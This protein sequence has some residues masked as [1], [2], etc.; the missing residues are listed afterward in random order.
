MRGKLQKLT[1]KLCVI[2]LLMLTSLVLEQNTTSIK[3]APAADFTGAKSAVLKAYKSYQ[4]SVDLSK[5]HIYNTRD[6]DK[7]YEILSEVINRTPGIFY[8]GQ[9]YTKIVAPANDQIRAVRLTYIDSFVLESGAINV[10]KIKRVQSQIDTQVQKALKSVNKSMTKLE[11]AMVLHD[12]LVQNIEYYNSNSKAFCLSEWGAFIKGKANCQGYALAYG[13]LM[14]KIGVPVTYVS[15]E[16]MTHM[17]NQIKISGKWYHVDITW[18]DPLE[19]TT[20]KDQP[21]LVLHDTFLCS[22]ASMKQRGYSGFTCKTANSKKY[23]YKFW[24]TVNSEIYYRNHKW[25]YQTTTAI[26]ERKS[27]VSGGA[28]TLYKA[29]GNALV[30]KDS[31]HYY[32]I[33][34]DHIFMYNRKTGKMSQVYVK[35]TDATYK[36]YT[37]AQ[38]S[39]KTKVLTIRLVNGKKILVVKKKVKNNG[40][41]A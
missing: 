5:Y 32:F 1:I 22:T 6:D 36:R 33:N 2:M 17:W 25:I 19:P 24:K 41:L 18:D 39:Y 12:Y 34:Y 3:A 29:G 7:L 4:T 30:R 15:S 28:K 21:G 35:P 13:I 20:K 14:K 9:K 26:K 31:N 38:L 8:A 11:K 40:L 16:S 27:L 10:N 37:V 23:D